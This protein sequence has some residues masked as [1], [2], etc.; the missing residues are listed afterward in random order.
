MSWGG[1]G[2]P[3]QNGPFAN[4][5]LTSATSW[6]TDNYEINISHNRGANFFN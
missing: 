5:H 4:F 2:G 6:S 3:P 1:G